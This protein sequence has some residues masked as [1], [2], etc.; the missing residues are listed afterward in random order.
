VHKILIVG[1][2]RSEPPAIRIDAPHLVE[3]DN[4]S[5]AHLRAIHDS[6]FQLTEAPEASHAYSGVAYGQGADDLVKTVGLFYEQRGPIDLLDILDHGRSGVMELGEE[7]LF[8]CKDKELTVGAGVPGQLLPFLAP[9]AR[10]RLLG[11]RTALEQD[12]RFLLVRLA[13]ALHWKV[14]VYG[15]IERILP[16]H[17]EDGVFSQAQDLL[18]SSEAAIDDCAPTVLERQQHLRL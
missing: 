16:G 17:F 15:T 6:E 5:A 8:R 7:T 14:V 4:L 18:Y 3:A 9:Q 1:L 11:C 12:G 13:Q 2:R 10:L